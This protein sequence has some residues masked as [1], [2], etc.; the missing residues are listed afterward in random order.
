MNKK[1][2]IFSCLLLLVLPFISAISIQ[3]SI[4]MQISPSENVYSG[5]NYQVPPPNPADLLFKAFKENSEV[6]AAFFKM[7][8]FMVI[9]AILSIIDVILRGFGMW[10]ASKNNSKVWF[11]LL[12]LISSLG[13]L[14]LIYLLISK[15]AKKEESHEK[16]K[17]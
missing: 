2:L 8:I 1:I 17:K 3:D 5:G 15:K 7:I 11:W 9:I 4:D 10:R 6:R 13:I 12:L 14:P 16:K